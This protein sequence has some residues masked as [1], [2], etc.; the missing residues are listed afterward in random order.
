MRPNRLSNNSRASCW[1]FEGQWKSK[2]RSVTKFIS[3]SIKLNEKM[4]LK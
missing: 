3:Y 2:Y 1:S 4:T